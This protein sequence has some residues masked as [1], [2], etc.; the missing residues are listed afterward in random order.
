MRDGDSVA[1][2]KSPISLLQLGGEHVA[3]V[4]VSGQGADAGS[5]L[6]A[7]QSAIAVGLGDEPEEQ[8]PP[9]PGSGTQGW[10]AHAAGATI[11]GIPASGGLAIGP[12]R[13]YAQQSAIVV[14]DHPGD[15]ISEGDRLQ[16][17]LN[18]AQ[19]E[20]DPLHDEGKT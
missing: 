19:A 9:A 12:V 10:V 7:L 3:V 4:R 18:A 1:Q 8:L 15:P 13:Q 17:A 20:A 11:V 5:A 16:N 14:E 2:G 6:G